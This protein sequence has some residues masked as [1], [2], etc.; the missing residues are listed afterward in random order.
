MFG[1]RD[2]TANSVSFAHSA[3]LA[4]LLLTLGAADLIAQDSTG[5]SNRGWMVGASLG[6]LGVGNRPAPLELTTVGVHFTHIQPG[7]LGA[8]ISLG[9]VP[10]A[11]A[12][13]VLAFGLRAGVTLPV[14]I[15]E[16]ILVLPSAG[17]TVC[18]AG[19]EGAAAGAYG[20]NFGGAAVIGTGPVGLRTGVTWHRIGASAPAIW[21]LELGFVRRPVGGH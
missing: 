2:F 10:R 16:G 21:L 7:R 15:N 1:D 6:M 18:G 11:L 3:R 12:E 8:D 19:G 14:R 4:A 9:T 5:V 13:A 17:V 20:F